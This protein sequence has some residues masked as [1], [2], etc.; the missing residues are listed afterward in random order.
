MRRAFTLIELLVVIAIIAI[1]ASILFPVFAQARNAAKKTSSMSN[2]RQISLGAVMYTSDNDDMIVPIRYTYGAPVAPDNGTKFWTNL[3]QPY[4]HN[5]QIF[6]CPTDKADD[7][8]IPAVTYAGRFAEN[9][10][11]KE[12]LIG[13]TP[14]Y[15]INSTYLNLLDPV[16]GQPGRYYNIPV[17]QGTFEQPA[18]TVMVAEGTMKD[19]VVPVGAPG[20]ATM[21][22]RGSIGYHSL[23]SPNDPR[24]I[25]SN[26]AA[27]DA[28]AQGH[29]WGRFDKNY[30]IVGWLDGHVKYTAISKLR[31]TGS[32]VEEQDRFWN[33]R[34]DQ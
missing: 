17:P 10:L 31:P 12:Y 13:L 28:R 7:P 26:Y 21:T 5:T 23:S 16:P 19:V 2:V 14:S 4:I 24:N 32:S 34:G 30:V 8:Y 9:N 22:I 3:L 1:L 18:S 20:G 33:G 15:S 11:Y 25:W 6:F 27:G 29:L